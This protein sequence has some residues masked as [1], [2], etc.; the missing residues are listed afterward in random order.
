MDNQPNTPKEDEQ[1]GSRPVSKYIR[2]PTA[3]TTT[4]TTSSVTGH[5][6]LCETNPPE[7]LQRMIAEK[8]TENYTKC[9]AKYN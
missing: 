7:K 8:T 9:I 2:T 1:S 4:Q 6:Q 3:P 5:N